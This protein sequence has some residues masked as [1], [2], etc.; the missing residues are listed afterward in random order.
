MPI[1]ILHGEKEE[2]LRSQCSGST[3]LK[4]PRES[5]PITWIYLSTLYLY[6]NPP[7]FTGRTHSFWCLRE[8][9]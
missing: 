1:S 2:Y 5:D 6:S 7:M 3:E 4:L 8:Q 9:F